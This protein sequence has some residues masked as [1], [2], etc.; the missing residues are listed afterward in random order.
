MKIALSI[1][2][3]LIVVYYL[4]FKGQKSGLSFWK[5]AQKNPELTYNFLLGS[6][7]WYVDDGIN[8]N[9]QPNMDVGEWD[10]PFRLNIPGIGWIQVF[11][12]V[13]F[14]EK[15]QTEFETLY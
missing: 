3:I 5:K 12:R 7:A 10:G 4:F 2:I 13:G 1:A 14:Y 9:S 11:G 8:N 15:S 6:D